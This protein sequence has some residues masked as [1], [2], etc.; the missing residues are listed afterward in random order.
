MK[1]LI[2]WTVSIVAL[3]LIVANVVGGRFDAP[4]YEGPHSDHFDGDRFHNVEPVDLPSLSRGLRYALTTDHGPWDPWREYPAFGPPPDR[5]VGGRLR[6]TYINH[7]TTLI[8]VDSLNV[9][10]DPI[11]S[12]RASPFSWIG[13]ERRHAPGVR[14]D[15]LPPIDIVLLSHNHYDHTDLPTL[16]TLRVEHDPLF[17][18]ELGSSALLSERGLTNVKELDWGQ[19]VRH[20]GARIVGQRCRHFPGRGLNDRQRTLWMSYI[21]ETP[22]GRVYFFGDTGYG[23]HFT[24]TGQQLGPFRL[25]ILPIGAFLPK[26]FM[27]SVHINPEEAIQAHRELGA[28]TSLAVHY[29]TFRLSEEGQDR[30]LEALRT[31]LSQVD[32]VRFWA[33]SPGEGRDVP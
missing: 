33:L 6:V 14:L 31:T 27:G 19:D 9:L 18:V 32:D 22:S 11:W 10:T 5:V 3:L 7:A 17:I 25:A 30:P 2:G 29:G 28:H 8:Q 21:L 20:R 15:Q 16:D 13:P 4:A 26:W 24:Q 23:S 12:E 1:K